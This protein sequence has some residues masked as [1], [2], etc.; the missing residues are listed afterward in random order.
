MITIKFDDAIII[1]DQVP[2]ENVTS[3]NLHD[4]IITRY[5]NHMISFDFH[6][7]PFENVTSMNLQALRESGKATLGQVIMMTAMNMRMVMII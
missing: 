7:V 1:F 4:D 3:M 6:Q 2:F 5:E